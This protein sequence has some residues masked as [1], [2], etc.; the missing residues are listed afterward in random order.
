M[1][2]IYVKQGDSLEVLDKSFTAEKNALVSVDSSAK[3]FDSTG[4]EITMY[5]KIEEK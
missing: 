1:K 4:N 3:Q 2:L 5:I